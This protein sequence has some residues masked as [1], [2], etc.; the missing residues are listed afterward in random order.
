M[1][2]PLASRVPVLT[3]PGNHEVRCGHRSPSP[4]APGVMVVLRST[5]PQAAGAAAQTDRR[6][7]VGLLCCPTPHSAA[8]LLRSQGWE[9]CPP[10]THIPTRP[11]HARSRATQ[12]EFQPSGTIFA[13]YNSR[14]PVPQTANP[15]TQAKPLAMPATPA[16]APTTNM[17]YSVD[18]P[19]VAHL[20]FITT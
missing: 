12:I 11:G 1:M 2:Q 15:A 16:E 7:H 8:S 13:A 19:G 9:R 4:Q 18:L 3:T 6:T 14:Y 20:V 10:F 5:S 17:Y